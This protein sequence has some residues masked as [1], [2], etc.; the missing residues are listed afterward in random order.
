MKAF[1]ERIEMF[2]EK[3]ERWKLDKEDRIQFSCAC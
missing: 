2:P 3:K 1:I